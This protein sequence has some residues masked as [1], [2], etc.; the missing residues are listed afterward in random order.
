MIKNL[1]SGINTISSQKKN[2]KP[3]ELP[4]RA[5]VT[6]KDSD[7]EDN[8]KPEENNEEEEKVDE[9]EK[10]DTKEEQLEETKEEQLE[11]TKEEQLE[12]TKEEEKEEVEEKQPEEEESKEEYENAPKL[13]I[14]IPKETKIPSQVSTPRS[15]PI[16]VDNITDEEKQ[17]LPYLLTPVNQKSPKY[18]PTSPVHTN[19]EEIDNES[20]EYLNYILEQLWLYKN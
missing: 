19:F 8:V 12:E 16:N 14:D 15:I 9:E 7:F 4:S 2:K 6:F 5:V 3:K 17:L 20:L 18:P 1:V 11:D 13:R 10:E